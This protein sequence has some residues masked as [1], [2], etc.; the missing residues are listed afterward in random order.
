MRNILAGTSQALRLRSRC[1]RAAG[2]K[3]GPTVE[4][5]AQPLEE[6]PEKN[7]QRCRSDMDPKAIK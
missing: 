7:L 5:V 1:A 6:D 4:E 2:T 3:Y